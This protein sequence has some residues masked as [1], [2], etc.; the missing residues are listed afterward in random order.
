MYKV[1]IRKQRRKRPL[2]T[3]ERKIERREKKRKREREKERERERERERII[4]R[5]GIDELVQTNWYTRIGMTRIGIHELLPSVSQKGVT[6]R[7][8]G[9]SKI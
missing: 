7:D 5:I 2:D 8:T 1:M 9:V 6:Y 4:T 3:Q